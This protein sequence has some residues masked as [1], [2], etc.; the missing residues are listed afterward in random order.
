MAT[1]STVVTSETLAEINTKLPLVGPEPSRH[2]LG[3]FEDDVK[4]ALFCFPHF[5]A[6]IDC[7][8]GCEIESSAD[9]SQSTH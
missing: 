3:A 9:F 8:N 4:H 2:L 1:L 6:D 7:S 5:E